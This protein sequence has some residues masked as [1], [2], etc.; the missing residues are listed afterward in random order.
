V[1]HEADPFGCTRSTR[2]SSMVSVAIRSSSTQLAYR[3]RPE[4]VALRTIGA[5]R[6]S[7]DDKR[8]SAS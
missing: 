5:L 8:S 3:D 2:S 4:R 6:F 7:V 1:R